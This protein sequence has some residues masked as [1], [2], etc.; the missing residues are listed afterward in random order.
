MVIEQD[1][2][3][4]SMEVK[5]SLWF[6]LKC[7]ISQFNFTQTSIQMWKWGGQTESDWSMIKRHWS[8]IVA[9]L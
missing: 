9:R 5:F 2:K 8:S 6:W 4:V 1:D 3:Y 7:G